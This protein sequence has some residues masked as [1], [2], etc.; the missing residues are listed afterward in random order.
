MFSIPFITGLMRPSF[1]ER[2]PYALFYAFFNL[3]VTFPLSGVISSLAESIW[4]TPTVEQKD[5]M[6]FYVSLVCWS[7]VGAII[8]WVSDVRG[9]RV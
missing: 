9:S 2:N 6:E 5:L 8:G 3:P 7:L 4:E 1:H